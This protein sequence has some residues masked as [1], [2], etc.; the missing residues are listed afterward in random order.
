[1][2]IIMKEMDSSKRLREIDKDVWIQFNMV[3]NPSNNDFTFI[4]PKILIFY[5]KSFESVLYQLY[6]FLKKIGCPFKKFMNIDEYYN[7]LYRGKY[8]IKVIF[9][10]SMTSFIGELEML[11]I[12]ILG[13][14]CHKITGREVTVKFNLDKIG[15]LRRWNFFEH[16]WDWGETE[17]GQKRIKLFSSVWD[18]DVLLPIRKIV[19]HSDVG[20]TLDTI[21]VTKIKSMLERDYGMDY[22]LI[23]IFVSDV[24]S[25]ICNNIPDHSKSLGFI[26]VHARPLKE[27]RIPNIEIVISDCGIGI[28]QSL[29]NRFPK[30]YRNKTH[31]K[32]IEEVLKGQFPYP[33]NESHGGI[34]RARNFV[35]KFNGTIFIRSICAKAG[36]KGN[37]T[38]YDMA[39]RFFPGTHVNILIPRISLK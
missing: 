33:K 8:N 5:F 29:Y 12:H 10:L 18:S 15:I 2:N 34:L 3:N 25:E 38:D 16:F 30:L 13:N 32:V 19:D 14:F 36:N 7:K 22:E 37:I 24:I 23:D 28:R 11:M 26:L 4:F 6:F 9:D 1:M 35:D 27:K 17:R 20:A 31:F 21:L 39:W